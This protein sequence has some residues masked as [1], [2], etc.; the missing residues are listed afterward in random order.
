MHFYKYLLQMTTSGA[1]RHDGAVVSE[2]AMSAREN[3]GWTVI[4]AISILQYQ[5]VFWLVT[6][7]SR[8]C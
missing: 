8:I 7:D 2:G 3:S 1:D 6:V 4:S 5:W